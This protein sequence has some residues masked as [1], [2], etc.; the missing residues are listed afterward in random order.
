MAASKRHASA[1]TSE[2]RGE[3]REAETPTIIDVT[4]PLPQSLAVG[5]RE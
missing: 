1:L 2:A 3:K 4:L 5:A